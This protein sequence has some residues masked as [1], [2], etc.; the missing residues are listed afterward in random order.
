MREALHVSPEVAALRRLLA[1]LLERDDW[2]RTPVAAQLEELADALLAAHRAGD[3]TIRPVVSS[4][5]PALCGA[6]PSR[7]L[8]AEFTRDDALLTVAREAGFER[9]E[10][11]ADARHRESFERAVDA[12][13]DGEFG[14]LRALLDAE[15]DLVTARSARGHRATLLHYLGSNGVETWRQV[16]PGNAVALAELLL[17]RGAEPDARAEIYGGS[18]TLALVSSSDHPRR[19]GLS[20]A[21]ER[22]LVEAGADGDAAAVESSHAVAILRCTDIRET[23]RVLVEELGF[24]VTFEWGE[25]LDFCGVRLGSSELFLSRGEQGAEGTWV[26]IFVDDV[27]AYRASIRAEVATVHREP[28]DEPWNVR[29]CVVSIPDGHVIRFGG[30]MR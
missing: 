15:P 7:I 23:Q 2:H 27:D 5:H 22:R 26:M 25:P 18:T 12:L 20:G 28:T 21:L 11:A 19:A 30:P 6:S 1:P 8:D 14:T 13:L 29:E 17:G 16:V 24:A 9:P 3:A 10:D 4:W